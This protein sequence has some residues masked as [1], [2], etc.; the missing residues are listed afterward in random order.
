M[1]K[2]I[3]SKKYVFRKKTYKLNKKNIV[4]KDILFEK[5]KFKK[6]YNNMNYKKNIDKLLNNLKII[7]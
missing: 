2:I 3:R 1:I 6:F 7:S 4:G 5:F